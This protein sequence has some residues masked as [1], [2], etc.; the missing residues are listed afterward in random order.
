MSTALDDFIERAR[1]VTVA[2]AAARL[3]LAF[4][5]GRKEHPQPCPA[6]GGKDCF[7]FHEEK[8]AWNCRKGG[9]GGRDA[10]GMAGHVLGLDLN[11]RAG[12]LEAC[13]AVLGEA[14]PNGG[15]TDEERQAREDRLARQKEENDRKAAARAAENEK[16]REA[17]RAKAR[18][19]WERAVPARGTAAETYLAARS[20]G[21]PLPPAA[22]FIA[23]EPYWHGQDERGKPVA[24]HTGAAMVLPFVD[25]AGRIIGCHLTW[26]DMARPPKFRPD[27]GLEEKGKPLATKKMRGSKSGGVIPLY[28]FVKTASDGLIVPDPARERF[29]VGEGIET[30][31]AVALAEGVRADTVY[32]AAGDLG[33]LAGPAEPSSAFPHPD[34]TFTDKAGRVR[35]VRVAGPVPKADQGP[36]DALQPPANARWGV[37]LADGDSEFVWTAATMARAKARLEAIPLGGQGATPGGRAPQNASD[38]LAGPKPPERHVTVIWPPAEMDFADVMTIGREGD[39]GEEE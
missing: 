29:V 10:I 37:L 18:G 3:K 11:D 21:G 32:C 36:E 4:L 14:A 15:E 35:A 23:D 39:H 1:G 7:S 12:F 24:I 9:A 34:R 31:R 38:P 27:L 19:K 26:I 13:A 6:C 30:V 16:Y 2:D 22:R 33:N 28:G 20:G 25:P 8:N 17:E 5:R